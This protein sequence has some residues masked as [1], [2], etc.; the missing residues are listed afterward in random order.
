MEISR[1]VKILDCLM[2]LKYMYINI[3]FF[4]LREAKS[5]YLLWVQR[6]GGNS[7]G[8]VEKDWPLTTRSVRRT[9]YR[10]L[11]RYHHFQTVHSAST[12]LLYIY[13]DSQTQKRNV[14]INSSVVFNFSMNC[15]DVLKFNYYACVQRCLTLQIYWKT[16]KWRSHTTVAMFL[17]QIPPI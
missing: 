9:V 13:T 15:T 17:S 8:S 12:Y 1:L 3:G 6:K 5:H 4:L 11:Q 10:S 2:F 7:R 16:I 14:F